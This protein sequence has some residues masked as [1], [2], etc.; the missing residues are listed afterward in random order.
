MEIIG[1]PAFSPTSP[2]F[3]QG[4]VQMEDRKDLSLQTTLQAKSGF[5]VNGLCAPSEPAFGAGCLR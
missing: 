4:S 1:K 2:G 3:S 5:L